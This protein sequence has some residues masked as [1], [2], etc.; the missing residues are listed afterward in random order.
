MKLF[1]FFVLFIFSCTA[2]ENPVPESTDLKNLSSQ[3]LDHVWICHH[4]GSDYHNKV[5]VEDLFPHGC[6][7]LGDRTKFCWILNKDDCSGELAEDWQV[8]NCPHLEGK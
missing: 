6:Y 5:C 7:V 8:L 3:P 1:L 4:P 2:L